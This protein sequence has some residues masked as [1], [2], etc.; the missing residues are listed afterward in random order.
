MR[1]RAGTQRASFARNTAWWQTLTLHPFSI[2]NRL[3]ALKKDR[4]EPIRAPDVLNLYQA[5]VKKGACLRI[6]AG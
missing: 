5:V 6:C 2:R 3:T 1:A 4:D